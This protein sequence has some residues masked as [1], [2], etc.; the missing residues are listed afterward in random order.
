M[1][2]NGANSSHNHGTFE[3]KVRSATRASDANQPV[4]A[5]GA[6]RQERGGGAAQVSGSSGLNHGYQGVHTQHRLT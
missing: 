2:A 3:R 6:S 5:G 1:N 4:A